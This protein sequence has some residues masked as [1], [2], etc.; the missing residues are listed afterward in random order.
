MLLLIS[1]DQEPEESPPPTEI[2]ALM[3]GRVKRIGLDVFFDELDQEYLDSVFGTDEVFDVVVVV[4]VL[5]D[6]LAL[7]TTEFFDVIL[8]VLV[9]VEP[10][11]PPS[12]DMPASTF[13]TVKILD[14]LLPFVDVVV[15]VVEDFELDFPPLTFRLASSLG[16]LKSIFD[17]M[18]VSLID[19]KRDSSPLTAM[20]ASTSGR[21]KISDNLVPLVDVVVVFVDDFRPSTAGR[22]KVPD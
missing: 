18:F 10:D 22:V 12:M 6:E 20:L 1:L 9:D 21:D 14:D 19:A 11:I 13:G 7:G 3:L 8:I 4:V 17:K 5:K 2:P 16:R 15:V